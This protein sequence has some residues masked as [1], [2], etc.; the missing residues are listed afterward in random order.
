MHR[1][2]LIRRSAALRSLGRQG[3]ACL[4][5]GKIHYLVR[6]LELGRSQSYGWEV[7]RDD[8][9]M[10]ILRSTQAFAT[11]AEA[12]A[13]SAKAAAPLALWASASE[14]SDVSQTTQVAHT[15]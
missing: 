10:V 3:G 14:S 4:G 5:D 15:A 2:R 8:D 12:L 6:V 11:R 7:C 9:S 13:D 1:R